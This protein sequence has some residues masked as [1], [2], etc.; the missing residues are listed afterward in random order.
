MFFVLVCVFVFLCVLYLHTC[1]NPLCPSCSP[2]TRSLHTGYLGNQR[3]C[4]V[5]PLVVLII[6]MMMIVMVLKGEDDDNDDDDDG[7]G[8]VGDHND[9]DDYQK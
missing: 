6:L 9:H 4:V 1:Y 2:C 3:T 5:V 7:G 8:G